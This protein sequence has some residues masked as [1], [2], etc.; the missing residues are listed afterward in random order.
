MLAS[1][2]SAT[3]RGYV[4]TMASFPFLY[5]HYTGTGEYIG[6]V[7]SK[8]CFTGSFV[9]VPAIKAY[10]WNVGIAALNLINGTC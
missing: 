10:E 2:S 7:L 3:I 4:V 9:F 5:T 1:V 8:L 6:P